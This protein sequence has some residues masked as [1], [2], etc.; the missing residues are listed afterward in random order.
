MTDT[1]REPPGSWHATGETLVAYACGDTDA[2]DAWSVEAHLAVCP[3][4]RGVV[5]AHV[6][7]GRLS[8]NRSV[9][10]VRASMPDDAGPR[11]VAVRAG[12]PDHVLR[13]L[14]ATP[15]LR[16]SWLL[17][18]VGVLTLTTVEAIVAHAL[19]QVGGPPRL[20]S[21]HVLVPFVVASPLLVL[22]S[23]AA[24]FLP[25]FDP[26]Y[27]LAAAAPFS[28]V[29]LLLVRTLATL[30]AAAI[31]MVC[32]GAL[33]PGPRW[34]PAALL[35]PSLALCML[36]LAAA[37]LV[38]PATAA[39]GVAMSWAVAV[40]AVAQH[41]PLLSVVGWHAQTASAIAVSGCAAV[42]VA[43]RRSIDLGW[44]R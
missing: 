34:V 19:M 42:L 15:S 32:I 28:G 30:L 31:P 43:R 16:L 40:F 5:N 23:V 10:L 2:I 17:G 12:V 36:A 37:T 11:R 18:M 29:R 25:T 1:L 13:L 14:A 27:R 6:D 20:G 38:R 21:Q 33:L 41:H 26:A 44:Q 4:C 7:A 39:I 22:A 35:G 3:R 9:L 24:A 8:R